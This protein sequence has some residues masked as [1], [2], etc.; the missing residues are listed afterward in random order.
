M[1]ATFVVWWRAEIGE[2]R[3]EVQDPEILSATV[4]ASNS[5]GN[6]NILKFIRVTQTDSVNPAVRL[7][8]MGIARMFEVGADPVM[9]ADDEADLD[10]N[11]EQNAGAKGLPIRSGTLKAPVMD[12]S[13]QPEVEKNWADGVLPDQA[14]VKTRRVARQAQRRACIGTKCSTD[15]IHQ[16]VIEDDIEIEINAFFLRMPGPQRWIMFQ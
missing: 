1:V 16:V 15:Q 8:E 4:T 3:N 13:P 7:R 2:C 10:R 12:S 11:V 6:R 14:S 5:I 9:V